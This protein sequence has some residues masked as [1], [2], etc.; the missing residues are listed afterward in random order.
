M[1]SSNILILPPSCTALKCQK[2]DFDKQK[3]KL[4]PLGGI[5]PHST[6]LFFQGWHPLPVQT[7]GSQNLIRHLPVCK[8][9]LYLI[10]ICCQVLFGP[11]MF[12]LY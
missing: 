6:L 7:V 3:Y 2:K 4:W 9:F 5:F 8:M 1:F 11:V 12:V 10:L